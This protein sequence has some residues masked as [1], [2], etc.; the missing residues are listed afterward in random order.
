MCNFIPSASGMVTPGTQGN[1]AIPPKKPGEYGR[2]DEVSWG[3]WGRT[4]RLARSS[5]LS[6]SVDS[7]PQAIFSRNQAVTLSAGSFPR[8][9]PRCENGGPRHLFL[10]ASAHQNTQ[11]PV[12]VI[13]RTP[14]CICR[15]TTSGGSRRSPTGEVHAQGSQWTCQLQG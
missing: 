1:P 13:H 6:L 3:T 4:E 9:L 8:C 14:I 5:S 2:C 10:C 15:G 7:H 12:A 11:P